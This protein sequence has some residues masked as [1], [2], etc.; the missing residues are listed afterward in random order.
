MRA[1]IAVLPGDG[2]GP[3]VTAE[4]VKV[5]RAVAAARG[6]VLSFEEAPFGAAALSG[7]HP[8]LPAAT[9]DACRRADAVLLGAVGGPEWDGLPPDRRPEAGLLALRREL[10]LYANLRPVRA[11]GGVAAASPLR[12]EA[13]EGTDFLIVRELTGGLYFGEPRGR[14]TTNGQRTAVDTLIYSEEE[15]SRVA[16]VAF[17]AA[18]L[19]RGRVT[20]VDKANVLHSSQLWREVV[21]EVALDYPDVTLDHMLVDSAAMQMVRR[22]SAFDVLVMENMFGDILSDL[23]AGLVGSLGL[24]PSASLGAEGPS[25]YEPVH[26]TA[27]DIA[28]RG[29]ANPSGAILSAALLLR[30]ALGLAE[31]AAL[32]ETAVERALASGARTADLAGGGPALSTA[33]FGDRVIALLS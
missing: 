33:G 11:F 7:G 18:G 16:R 6:H 28:G 27:P 2:V 8:P 32:V 31:E 30:Y 3:E 25:L 22:P 9:L 24:L 20:S 4:A 15:I 12:P 10:R 13:L 19:R 1:R 23:G 29:L 5:L 21:D 14:T 17:E 26:G